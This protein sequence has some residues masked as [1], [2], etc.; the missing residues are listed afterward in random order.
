[1]ELNITH[2]VES[3]DDMPTLSGSQAELG[4]DAGKITWNN[5]KAYAEANPILPD[6]DAR[7][8]ARQWLQGFGAWSEAEIAAWSNQELDALVIQFI[9]GDIRE[10]EAFES[11]AEY[12]KAAE[13][14]TAGGRIYKGDSGQW[15]FYLG[16]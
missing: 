4:R 12:Q 13:D 14:G 8:V 1:M 6:D 2:M 5:S 15:F 16:D 9:A 3:A 7:D 11:E 10:M